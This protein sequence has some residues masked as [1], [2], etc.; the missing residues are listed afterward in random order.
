M[1]PNLNLNL[2]W[3]ADVIDLGRVLGGGSRG[4]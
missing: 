4:R 1:S 3:R 2:G